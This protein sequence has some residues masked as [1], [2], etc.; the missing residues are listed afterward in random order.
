[1]LY[2]SSFQV[3]VTVFWRFCHSKRNTSEMRALNQPNNHFPR[4]DFSEKV[5]TQRTAVEQQML[6]DRLFE[7]H[8]EIV[9]YEG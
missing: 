4:L 5:F 9:E 8:S 2:H 3:V 6:K 7:A 1:M